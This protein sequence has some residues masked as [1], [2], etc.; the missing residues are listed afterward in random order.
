MPPEIANEVESK[1]SKKHDMSITNGASE[2][3]TSKFLR[4]MNDA[5]NEDGILEDSALQR[6]LDERKIVDPSAEYLIGQAEL[7]GI[8]IRISPKSWSWL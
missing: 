2:L 3:S 6:I 4:A 8:L 5:T 7:E 1:I